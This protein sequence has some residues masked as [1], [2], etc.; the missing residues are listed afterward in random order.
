MGTRRNASSLSTIGTYGQNPVTAP[1]INA[2]VRTQSDL[3]KD[4]IKLHQRIA[5]EWYKKKNGGMQPRQ[6][7][8][9]EWYVTGSFLPQP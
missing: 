4:V 3:E 2:L 7:Q 9:P 6:E 1:Y 5:D 8:F